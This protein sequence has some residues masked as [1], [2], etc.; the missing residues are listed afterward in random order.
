MYKGFITVYEEMLE[1]YSL[2]AGS[3]KDVQ[4]AL[5]QVALMRT[6]QNEEIPSSTTL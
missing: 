3:V 1:K 2:W 5:D 4:D 6:V